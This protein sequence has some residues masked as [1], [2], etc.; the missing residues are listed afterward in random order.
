MTTQQQGLALLQRTTWVGL[1]TVVTIISTLV[2]AC[3]TPFA[4][5]AALAALFLPRR[6]AFVL[7]GV[8]WIA[9]QAIGF[10]LLNYPLNWDCYRGGINLGIAAVSCTAAAMLAQRVLRKAGRAVAVT[11]SFAAAFVTYEV[12]LFAISPWRSG[13]D[14]AMSVVQYILYIN[15]IAFVGLLLLQSIATSIGLVAPRNQFSGSRSA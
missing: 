2:V 13:G 9:N 11:G 10:G 15:G 6:D 7:I 1:L 4:A 12:V 3:G 5:L 8:N 14:F